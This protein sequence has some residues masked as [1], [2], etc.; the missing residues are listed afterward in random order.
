MDARR[1]SKENLN[2]VD[3]CELCTAVS[4][5]IH[6]FHFANSLSIQREIIVYFLS[7]S[8]FQRKS[9]LF[10]DVCSPVKSKE[11][12]EKKRNKFSIINLINHNYNTV[13]HCK[14]KHGG[15]ER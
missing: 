2:T 13:V 3:T 10:I 1:F 6:P 5:I 4:I 14:K 8:P 11:T 12:E 15:K 7:S 9:K